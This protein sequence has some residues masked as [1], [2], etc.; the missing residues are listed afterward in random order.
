MAKITK[1]DQPVVTS[2]KFP[3]GAAVY[4]ARY[5]E[6]LKWSEMRAK[7]H[8]SARSSRFLQECVDHV[9]RTPA[10]LERHPEMAVLDVEATDFRAT[11]K[12]ARESGQ[13]LSILQARTG[14]KP[15]D[16]RKIVGEEVGTTSRVAWGQRYS[17]KIKV[18][19]ATEEAA[20]TKPA[21]KRARKTKPTADDTLA[22]DLAAS[23]KRTPRK[24]T[25]RKTKTVA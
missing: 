22:A 17:G 5:G 20:E 23:V 4:E 10:L 11:V 2:T 15:A 7:F 21:T 13:G 25:P 9:N 8:V 6:G 24:R 1:Q 14:L 18:A 12:A 16:L 19:E 3:S